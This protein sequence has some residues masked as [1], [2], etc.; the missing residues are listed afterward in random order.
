[1]WFSKSAD[2]RMQFWKNSNPRFIIIAYNVT[3]V[4]VTMLRM[5]HFERLKYIRHE[6]NTLVYKCRDWRIVAR[7]R[8][9]WKKPF[10]H[11]S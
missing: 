4:D 8:G 9:H 10:N 5:V 2:T 6:M 7:G 1:M 11:S 3:Y